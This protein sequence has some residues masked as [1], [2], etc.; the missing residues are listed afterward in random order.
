MSTETAIAPS[1]SSSFRDSTT[2]FEEA[3]PTEAPAYAHSGEASQP[4]EPS[5]ETS[6]SFEWHES[7]PPPTPEPVQ[8]ASATLAPTVAPSPTPNATLIVRASNKSGASGGSGAVV[9][10]T[11]VVVGVLIVLG[12][13]IFIRR[14]RRN[15]RFIEAKF[16][17][18]PN[19]GT[20]AVSIELP[21]PPPSSRMSFDPM[22]QSQQQH[23]QRL[24][25]FS[26]GRGNNLGAS[27]FNTSAAAV[28]PKG[29]R[30]QQQPAFRPDQSTTY[31]L[32][33]P[34]PSNNLATP[35]LQSNQPGTPVLQ[36][37]PPS[38]P[39]H[40]PDYG[41]YKPQYDAAT[42]ADRP[43]AKIRTT[44][45]AASPFERGLANG[46][47]APRASVASTIQ[48]FHDSMC[49]DL[50]KYGD[51]LQR[52]SRRESSRIERARSR[53]RGHSSASA[54]GATRPNGSS[55][56]LELDELMP[57]PQ[58]RPPSYTTPKSS[59]KTLSFAELTGGS[60]TRAPPPPLPPAPVSPTLSEDPYNPSMMSS[61]RYHE[62]RASED[63][64]G[65]HVAAH[66]LIATF[67]ASASSAT[68]AA[69]SDG[70]ASSFGSESSMLS[71]LTV[72][73]TSINLHSS[74][75]G[76]I[77]EKPTDAAIQRLSD[78]SSVSSDM[79]NI[80]AGS[81]IELK[82]VVEVEN[83]DGKAKEIEI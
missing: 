30:H 52:D 24:S 70:S 48:G 27:I 42:S 9:S 34:T 82:Q 80:R 63:V 19:L 83:D 41:H 16:Q 53:S 72:S 38:R 29:G 11:L 81:L 33:D 22:T 56:V 26:N 46:A 74:I 54:A 66:T 49:D 64:A 44:S 51:G 25:V 10:V 28:S 15:N 31:R 75:N 8:A 12:I 23:Q 40:Q 36:A 39:Q 4:Q 68:S 73:S 55:A 62:S 79:S 60:R 57:L 78:V 77:F 1:A 6:G 45:T 47:P 5:H 17:H 7:T 65:N 13:I 32:M 35:I 67:S 50:Y 3:A 43:S 59:N 2:H 69:A 37:S 20:P 76:R 14:R 21:P 71:E 18:D 61:V 58:S